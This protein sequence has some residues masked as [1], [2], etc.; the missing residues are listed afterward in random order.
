MNASQLKQILR[1]SR[2]Q[3]KSTTVLPIVLGIGMASAGFAVCFVRPAKGASVVSRTAD[4]LLPEALPRGV[5]TVAACNPCNPCN[6]CAGKNP[7]NPCNPCAAANP[8][9]P[10]AAACPNPCNPCCANP[11]AAAG[12]PC[13]PCNPCAA[14]NPC[15]PC[16]PCAAANPCN[17]CAAANPCNPCAAAACNPCN[18]CAAAAG[19][20]T[21][22]VIPRLQTAAVCNPCAAKNPCNPCNP[23]AAANPCNPCN[24][25]A[26]A[27]PCN[28]C[29]PCAAANPC[30]PCNPCAAANPC[31]PCNPCAA[32]AALELTDAEAAT[33]YDCVKGY[34]QAAYSVA[35]NPAASQFLSWTSYSLI[36]YLS[37]THGGRYVMNYANAAAKDYGKFE[38]VGKLP[39]GAKIAKN[40][41]VVA[42]NGKVALGPLFLMEKMDA[43]FNPESGDWRY[44]MIMPDGST[45]GA[46]K[47]KNS[48]GVAFC[49]ECHS[50]VAAEQDYLYFLPEEYRITK[51]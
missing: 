36:P 38:A 47:G 23:C 46:T 34:Q 10:C 41:F 2:A 1:P 48:A 21:E 43:G 24:P 13:N 40:S 42:P 25:C 29:N 9:N 12:N 16:N 32:G 28:P 30:N 4:G 49:N 33:V 44:T 11:C 6:P 3:L 26:A 50:V 15:N 39:P 8:C 17:P 22:C 19:G 7:C 31:N 45:F 27:N 5:R 37:A 14:K 35:D 18:P 51:K 20:A